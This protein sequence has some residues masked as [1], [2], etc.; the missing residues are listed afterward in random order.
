[1]DPWGRVAVRTPVSRPAVLLGG[2][3]PEQELTP[4]ARLGDAFAFSCALVVGAALLCKPRYGW[5]KLRNFFESGLRSIA[6]TVRVGPSRPRESAAGE[7][8]SQ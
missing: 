2:V 3:R 1:V 7:I 8:D 6:R 4:Y 5:R